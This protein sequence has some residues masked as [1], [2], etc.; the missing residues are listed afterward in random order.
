MRRKQKNRASWI[1]IISEFEKTHLPI[2]EFASSYGV[3]EASIYKWQRKL[4]P[5]KI[6]AL[7]P[8][9]TPIRI[10]PETLDT[11]TLTFF[12]KSG[13]S[14]TLPTTISPLWLGEFMGS[15]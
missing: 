8:T 12:H 13:H 5:Q 6:I 2:N 10:E 11:S 4:S 15:L 14:L 3:S 1:K 7:K 9:L